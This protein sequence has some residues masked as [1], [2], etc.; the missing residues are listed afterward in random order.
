M[1]H[2]AADRG[3]ISIL[4]FLIDF[5]CDINLV[6]AEGQTALHYGVIVGNPDVCKLLVSS[7]CRLDIESNDGESVL[8]MKHVPDHLRRIL[9]P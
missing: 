3:Y 7:G 1:I 2:W 9:F 4:Q 5:E 8:N 6:D